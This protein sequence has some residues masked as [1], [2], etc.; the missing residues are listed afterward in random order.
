MPKRVVVTG[1]AGFIGSEV[2]RQLVDRGYD[3][4]VI[5]DLSKEGHQP[6]PGVDFQKA[7]LTV[8]GVAEE[9]FAGYD[10][11]LNLAA[12]IG[13]I[14]YFHEYPATILAEND[15]LYAMTFEAAVRHRME[16][17]VYVSSSMVF[18]SATRFPSK[19]AD[20]AEIPP[21]VSAYGFSKL[22]GEWYCRAFA[23]QFGQKYTICRP[24]NAYGINEFPGEEVGY[25]HVIP[26]L[27]KKILSGQDPI[28]ILGDGEQT[29]CFTHVSDI[30]RGVIMSLESD[31]AVNQDFNIS[32]PEE[33]RILDLARRIFDLCDTGR[34]FAW[35]P[36]PGF[37]Y[38]IR[39]RIP[40]ATRATEVLGFT[41][42]VDLDTG[43]REVIGWL[44]DT[45]AI[46]AAA[47][48]VGGREAN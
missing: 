20:L 28:E 30:A 40:D 46:E 8:K 9:L 3:V 45:L 7:D 18:E 10:A 34:Q 36:V 2:T 33:T 25:A 16:R 38:D 13:G 48:V 39:R 12:K 42:E 19:E 14:G 24:F 15:K 37:T 5:D 35:T 27:A 44:R 31:R 29:R 41:A 26:D 6:P 11:C 22:S 17:V 4:R 21:P 43:L 32:S 1:G 23:D 47:P